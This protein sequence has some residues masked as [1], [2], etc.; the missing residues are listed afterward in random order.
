MKETLNFI[1][2]FRWIDA[3]VCIFEDKMRSELLR[4]EIDTISN[5]IKFH[6]QG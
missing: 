3:T 1:S 2:H 6:F 5:C 4:A